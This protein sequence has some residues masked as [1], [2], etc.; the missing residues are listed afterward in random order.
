MLTLGYQL[1]LT[2]THGLT[3]DDPTE[4]AVT[5]NN[6]IYSQ[7]SHTGPHETAQSDH[8]DYMHMVRS[9]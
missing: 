9:Y 3:N 1:G 8:Q 6:S 2:Y 4:N 7:Y 5:Q